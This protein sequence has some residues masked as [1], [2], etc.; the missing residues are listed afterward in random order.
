MKKKV[1]IDLSSSFPL[2]FDSRHNFY[3]INSIRTG[4][5]I[6]ENVFNSNFNFRGWGL[7]WELSVDGKIKPVNTPTT[8]FLIFRYSKLHKKR[9]KSALAQF[10][11]KVAI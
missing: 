2:K 11:R 10:G 8:I 1:V 9:W 5:C 3:G 4:R 6:K 7:K